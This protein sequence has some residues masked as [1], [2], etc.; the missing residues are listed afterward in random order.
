MPSPQPRSSILESCF[1]HSEIILKSF[2]AILVVVNKIDLNP[3]IKEKLKN[4]IFISAKNN[5]GIEMLKEKLLT[6]VNTE[7][8]SNNETI[9]T[10][11]R[12]YDELQHTLHEINTITQGIKDGISG[13][14]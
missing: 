13:D 3:K 8:I 5:Q 9:V 12:H 1:T 2:L 7:E 14:F 11:L 10:N 4:S 6:F